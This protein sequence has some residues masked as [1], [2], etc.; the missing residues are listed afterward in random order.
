MTAKKP[1]APPLAAPRKNPNLTCAHDGGWERHAGH[2]KFCCS[3][4]GLDAF[5]ARIVA[6]VENAAS[7]ALVGAMAPFA[8]LLGR[9]T[10]PRR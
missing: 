4:C 5:E 6:A 9:M 10:G 2:A 3:R 8:G 7:S 1:M